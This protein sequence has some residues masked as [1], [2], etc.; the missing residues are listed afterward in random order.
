MSHRG[1]SLRRS[2]MHNVMLGEYLSLVGYE[3]AFS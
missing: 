3:L 1:M 2:A